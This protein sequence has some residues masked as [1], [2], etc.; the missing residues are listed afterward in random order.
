MKANL[1]GGES[2]WL[3]THMLL[4]AE[5]FAIP[6]SLTLLYPRCKRRISCNE[7]VLGLFQARFDRI[8][9]KA[10]VKKYLVFGAKEW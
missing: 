8:V 9:W 5:I 7:S 6:F 10:I 3:T 1:G 4:A 2:G